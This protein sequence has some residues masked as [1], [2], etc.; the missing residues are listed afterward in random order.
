MEKGR[1]WA[2]FFPGSAIAT[3]RTAT[4][5]AGPPSARA[6]GTRGAAG[7]RAARAASRARCARPI[8]VRVEASGIGVVGREAGRIARMA[9]RTR[10]TLSLSGTGA[11]WAP[12]RVGDAALTLDGTGQAATSAPLLNTTWTA[13]FTVAAWVRLAPD[14]TGGRTAVAQDG[15]TESMFRLGYRDDRDLTGDGVADPAWCFTVKAADST[16]AAAA[17]ACTSDYLIP[18]DWVNLVGVFDPAGGT[19][20]L[21]L[22]VN[23]TPAIGG[24]SAETDATAAWSAIGPF[25]VGRAWSAGAPA[26]GWI[27]D[28]DEVYG[29][30]RVWSTADINRQAIK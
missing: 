29:V 10:R 6:T 8:T 2:P 3:L 7:A 5:A 4:T 25:A 18:G 23:G 30:Q 1:P 17:A 20:K 27:G 15:T 16:A 22:Y 9:V 24:S 12:G 28:I 13:G 14:V 21:R 11:G 26:D 19:P